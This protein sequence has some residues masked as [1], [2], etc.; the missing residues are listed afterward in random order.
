MNY[1]VKEVY[2]DES[3]QKTAGVKARDDVETILDR[4][5]FERIILESRNENRKNGNSLQKFFWHFKILN[6]WLKS[7]EGLKSGDTLFVQIPVMEHSIVLDRVFNKLKNRGVK[8]ILLIHDLESLRFS[9]RKELGLKTRIRL[10][11]EDKVLTS[12]NY[13]IV[14]NTKMKRIVASKLRRK[15]GIISLGLFDYIIDNYDT[16]RAAKIV[17]T[18]ND[19]VIIAGTLRKNKAAYAYDLPEDLKVNLY[20]V[21]YEG[22]ETDT[23]KYLGA[24]EPEELPYELRGSF[25]IVWDGETSKD[26]VGVYGEYLKINNPHKTSLYLASGIPVIIWEKAALADI[27]KKYNCGI[28]VNSL[29]EI[30]KIL[31]NMADEDYDKMKQNTEKMSEKLRDGFFLKNAI[32]KCGCKIL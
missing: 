32:Q 15:D 26:C 1:Y 13:I 11:F 25:G 17:R 10:K 4:I 22:V 6:I 3:L 19:P 27:V 16:E 23:V 5:G 9:K 8:V 21:G 7:T 29:L 18:K 14:H 12:S 31:S 2:K 24:F 20:G 28:A 30:N